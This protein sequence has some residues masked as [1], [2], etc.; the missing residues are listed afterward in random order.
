MSFSIDDLTQYLMRLFAD[1]A[2]AASF[3]EAPSEHLE[4]NGFGAVTQSDLDRALEQVLTRSSANTAV[5]VKQSLA[6]MSR[7]GGGGLAVGGG[8]VSRQVVREVEQPIVKQIH[9]HVTNV[10]Q[11][12]QTDNHNETFVDN[13]VLNNITADGDVRL[14]VNQNAVTATGGG[15]AA[16]GNIDGSAVN[17]GNLQGVQN[18]A[19]QV[20]AKGAIVGD[21]N[22]KVDANGAK[23]VSVGGNA[24]NVE[25]ENANLGSGDLTN[26]ESGKRGDDDDDDDEGQTVV[27]R[28][29]ETTGK[30]DVDAR[31]VEG[32]AN[33]AIG[34]KNA[35]RA[36]QGNTDVEDRSVEDNSKETTTVDASN[37]SRTT[38][39]S[40][41]SVTARQN[42]DIDK[43]DN[44]EQRA[45]DNRRVEDNSRTEDNDEADVRLTDTRLDSDVRLDDSDGNNVDS[46]SELDL[47]N[48][49]FLNELDGLTDANNDGFINELD[50]EGF[51]GQD[52]GGQGLD[53]AD[54]DLQS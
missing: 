25:A 1:D 31:N 38:D 37:R 20:D 22:V 18:A 7:Q 12:F 19:G 21:D 36:D 34:D 16:G 45:E 3:A 47:N 33:A 52:F 53:D 28:G 54:L 32:N 5:A 29:N 10:H 43:S 39:E 30:V 48:D 14:D 11:N 46:L 41:N 6:E 44:S 15:V 4:V 27:G 42:T 9:E 23:A 17:T 24:T 40:D 35:Q 50:A 13:R 8:G 2:E 49:G 51:D 26:V